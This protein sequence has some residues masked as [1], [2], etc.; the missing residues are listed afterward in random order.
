LIAEVPSGGTNLFFAP[1]GTSQASGEIYEP[2]KAIEGAWWAPAI[3][4]IGAFYF[5]AQSRRGFDASD[6]G[7]HQ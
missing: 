6:T 2:F 5:F 7:H 1:E 4:A 3:P